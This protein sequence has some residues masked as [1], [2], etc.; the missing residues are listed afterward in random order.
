[1][2]P[3]VLHVFEMMP[4]EAVVKKSTPKGRWWYLGDNTT[5]EHF[6]SV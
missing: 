6:A 5:R 4:P 1:M 2:I 3:E